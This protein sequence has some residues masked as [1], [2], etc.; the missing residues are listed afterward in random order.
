MTRIDQAH[1]TLLQEAARVCDGNK[2]LMAQYIGISVK[3]VYNW[4]EYFS[5]SKTRD[6]EG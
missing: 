4:L 6:Q 1:Y 2:T 3:T 5:E